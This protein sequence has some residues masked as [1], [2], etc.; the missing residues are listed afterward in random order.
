MQ[1][2]MLFVFKATINIPGVGVGVGEMLLFA[3]CYG[4]PSY[5]SGARKIITTVDQ[6]L[7]KIS[8]QIRLVHLKN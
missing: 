8:Y 6:K 2:I 5:A 4:K 3:P 7:P 1:N